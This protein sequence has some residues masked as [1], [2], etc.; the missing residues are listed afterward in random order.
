MVGGIYSRALLADKLLLYRALRKL[1]IDYPSL[2]CNVFQVDDDRKVVMRPVEKIVF[3][4]VVEILVDPVPIRNE[5]LMRDLAETQFSQVYQE[6]PLFKLTIPNEVSLC[7]AFEHTLADGLVGRYFHEIFLD[8]LAYCDNDD[9][10]AE[11]TSLYGAPPAEFLGLLVLFSLENDTARFTSSVPPPLEMYMGSLEVVE[12]DSLHFSKQVPPDYP[13]LWPGRFLSKLE[14]SIAYKHLNLSA[15]QLRQVLAQCKLHNVTLTSY[16]VV[17]CAMALQP[18]FGPSHHFLVVTAVTLRRFLSAETV[19]LP[20]QSLVDPTKKMLGLH[21]HGGM[22]QLF[23]P[24][25]HFS[26]DLVAHYDANM[27]KTVADKQGLWS[28]LNHLHVPDWRG[29][30]ASEFASTLG[31]SKLDSL[32]LSNLGYVDFPSHPSEKGSP[33]TVKDL[34]FWQDIAPTSEFV[35]NV[36]STPLGGLNVVISYLNHTFTDTALENFDHLAGDIRANLLHNAGCA[37]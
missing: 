11:Y 5:T 24:I 13:L 29:D 34:V 30:N 15:S 33:W 10:H 19:E 23:A 35:A 2:T 28:I 16:V 18:I 22:A 21:S 27:R 25:D 20:Y 9:N 36:I 6:K 14:R 8:S 26:W 7:A 32:K 17:N 37:E 1:L 4:D 12:I 31:K 3:D